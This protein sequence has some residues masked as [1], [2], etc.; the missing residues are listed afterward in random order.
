V[1]FPLYDRGITKLNSY[2][3]DVLDKK[4]FELGLVVEI[5]LKYDFLR[6]RIEGTESSNVSRALQLGEL[7]SL[8]CLDFSKVKLLFETLF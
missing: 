4:G 7:F 6:D 2:T 1:S 3:N 8:V 5:I